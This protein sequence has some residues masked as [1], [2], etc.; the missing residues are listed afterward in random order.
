MGWAGYRVMWLSFMVG[1]RGKPRS[2]MPVMRLQM[3]SEKSIQGLLVLGKNMVLM[4]PMQTQKLMIP[5]MRRQAQARYS[6]SGKRET[7]TP[8]LC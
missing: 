1:I 8:S 3:K 5:E 2:N 4:R 6:R 7:R